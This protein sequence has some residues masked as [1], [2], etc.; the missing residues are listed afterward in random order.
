MYVTLL[1]VLK[2]NSLKNVIMSSSA[3]FHPPQYI[4]VG[5][6]EGRFTTFAG[7]S[8]NI[9]KLDATSSATVF[10]ITLSNLQINS[11]INVT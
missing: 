5:R 1:L 11:H 6:Q 4:K 9:A 8:I 10:S 3:E 2:Q 7:S